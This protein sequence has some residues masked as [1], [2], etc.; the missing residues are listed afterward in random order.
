MRLLIIPP[1]QSRIFFHGR[2]RRRLALLSVRKQLQKVNPLL[3]SSQVC[4]PPPHPPTSTEACSLSHIFALRHQITSMVRRWMFEVQKQ[5]YLWEDDC[6]V[7][8]WISSQLSEVRKS[9]RNR[10]M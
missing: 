6:A 9:Y 8:D 4:P 10:N 5:G 3:S 7:A 2:L 1:F